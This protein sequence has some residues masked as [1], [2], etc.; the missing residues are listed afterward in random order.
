MEGEEVRN[1]LRKRNGG[2][3]DSYLSKNTKKKHR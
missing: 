2:K 3:I 1:L